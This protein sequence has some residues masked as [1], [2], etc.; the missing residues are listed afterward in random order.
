MGNLLND[1]VAL[2]TVERGRYYKK[3]EISIP[4]GVQRSLVLGKSGGE[5]MM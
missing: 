3:A 5:G 4:F 2:R 1:V